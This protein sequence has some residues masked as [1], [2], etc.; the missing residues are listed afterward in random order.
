MY[1]LV[2]ISLKYQPGPQ[3]GNAVSDG[4]MAGEGHCL[5]LIVISKPLSVL[6]STKGKWE[7]VLNL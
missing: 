1:L 5:H 3:Q 4:H 2:F 6:V 7:G